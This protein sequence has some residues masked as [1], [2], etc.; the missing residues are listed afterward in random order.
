MGLLKDSGSCDF[1]A[2]YPSWMQLDHWI[3]W[4]FNPTGYCEDIQWQ[5]LGMSMPQTMVLVNVAY[6]VVLMVVLKSEFRRHQAIG[7]ML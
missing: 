1:V 5:F 7:D 4:L 3:P 6:V 2:N